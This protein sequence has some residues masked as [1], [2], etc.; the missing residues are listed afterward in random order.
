MQATTTTFKTTLSKCNDGVGL[1]SMQRCWYL[2]DLGANCDDTCAAFGRSYSFALPKQDVTPAL[3]GHT[4]AGNDGPWIFLECYVPKED[5]YHPVDPTAWGVP[6]QT[7]KDELSEAGQH[8][9]PTC[10]L[11]CPCSKATTTTTTP[12]STC[13]DGIGL[14][15]GSNS[16]ARCWYLSDIG[17]NCDNTCAVHGSSYSY[18]SSARDLTPTL[19]GHTPKGKDEPW[20]FLECYVPEEDRYHPANP[21]AWGNPTKTPPDEL[22]EAGQ[23]SYPTC[24]LA[25]PCSQNF[26]ASSTTVLPSREPLPLSTTLTISTSAPVVTSPPASTLT[27]VIDPTYSPSTSS[28]PVLAKTTPN[29]ATSTPSGSAGVEECSG[30]VSAGRCWYLSPLGTSCQDTCAS[31]SCS[32]SFISPS[33]DMTPKLLGRLPSGRGDAFS[34]IECY[35]PGSDM[36]FP[37][38]P[39]ESAADSSWHGA[40]YSR[41]TC[42]LT[43][44]CVGTCIGNGSTSL[45][46]AVRTTTLPPVLSA[47]T[48][49]IIAPATTPTAGEQTCSG[50]WRGGRCWYLSSLGSNCEDT[51]AAHGCGY[52][53]SAPPVGDMVPILTG[54]VPSARKFPWTEVECY[55]PETDE[56]YP[57]NEVEAS[58]TKP[59]FAGQFSYGACR[60]SCSCEGKCSGNSSAPTSPPQ[61]VQSTLSPLP[62]PKPALGEGVQAYNRT[63]YL[64]RVGDNCAETCAANGLS[65]SWAAPP[66]GETVMPFLLVKEPVKKNPWAFVECYTPAKE[67]YHPVNRD[68][69]GVPGTDAVATKKAALWSHDECQLACPCA[70]SASCRWEQPPAC[71]PEFDWKGVIYRGCTSIG[72]DKPWCMHHEQH[73]DGN[74]VSDGDWSNCVQ[75]CDDEET[76][77]NCGWVP[78]ES[79]QKEFD[80]EGTH[81]VGC[82]SVEHDSPWCSN[83]DPYNRS[84][85]HCKYQCKNPSAADKK[86]IEKLNKG[87]ST[88][89]RL[90][91][92]QPP[93][94]CSPT[95]NYQGTDYEG[96]VLADNPTPWCSH[97]RSHS[98]AWSNCE[99]VCEDVSD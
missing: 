72:H 19:I 12:F 78:A 58:G 56:Y 65:Y 82:T 70:S 48:S 10:R 76:V 31:H 83:T 67:M 42:R 26:G 84:W 79:C 44:S 14:A 1:A 16:T 49:A 4:P 3:I 60:L 52:S 2:S 37:Y 23:H 43:C 99:K 66:S 53:F 11:A 61:M 5:R 64:S 94:A 29:F 80:Y 21:N 89:N 45:A 13:S 50:I 88:D 40:Q 28:A 39:E 87:A 47:T 90:C 81:Y 41:E 32:F 33:G 51:C 46:S 7:P 30:I 38:S 62:L 59:A 71:A 24:R 34:P 8:T 77:E 20:I 36:Y 68:A 97:D 27:P 92:W 63:W 6:G 54:H 69:W 86:T 9:Y 96:C 17:A 75:T 25:C 98:G 57:F 91:S 22:Q 85:S 74:A 18:S 93:Q 55:V 15:T 35:T 73:T 95:F